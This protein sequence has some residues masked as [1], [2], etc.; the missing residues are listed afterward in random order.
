MENESNSTPTIDMRIFILALLSLVSTSLKSQSG[1]DIKHYVSI[2]AGAPKLATLF[3]D[4][5]EN[6][7]NFKATGRGPFH[8]KYENRVNPFIGI[9]LSINN[10]S[11]SITYQDDV[12]DTA[13]GV[14]L[15]NNIKIESNNT[16]FNFRGNLHFINPENN[17][18]LDVYFGLGLGFRVGK[19]HVSSTY[20]QYTPSIKLPNYSVIGLETTFGI[21][22]FPIE[23]IGL[24]AEIGPAKS[25]IQGGLTCKF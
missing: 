21:R 24:Y 11:Y 3:F 9:G 15:P 12:I 25:I 14:I 6:E 1:T 4:I 23:N 10:M 22:Y 18:K 19:I 13:N 5:Y 17:D 2:G 7:K 20:E 8:F 16:A